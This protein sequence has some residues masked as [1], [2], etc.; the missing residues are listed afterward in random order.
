MKN[1]Q[2]T[3]VLF[4]AQAAMIAAVYTVLTLLGAFFFLWRSPS[5]YLRGT[6]YSSSIYP[7]GN[8]RTIYRLSA[9]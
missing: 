2:Q 8:S 6:D 4:M 5:P 7:C 9:Q 1:L 3:K